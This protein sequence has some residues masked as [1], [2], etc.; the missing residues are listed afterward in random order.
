MY[1]IYVPVLFTALVALV[2]VCAIVV[3]TH[4]LGPR[5]RTH[6]KYDIPYESGADPSGDARLRFDVKFYL[7]AILFVVFDLEVVYFY[8]WA[9]V[10]RDMIRGGPGILWIMLIFAFFLVVGFAHEWK[11]GALDWR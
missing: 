4:L 9:V 3:G 11:K 1:P 6:V 10:F 5:K 2:M 8:P 7:V